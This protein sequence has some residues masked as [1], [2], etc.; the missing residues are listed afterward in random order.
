MKIKTYSFQEAIEIL[1]SQNK[2]NFDPTVELS[3]NLN[4]DPKYPDQKIKGFI[5]F[6]KILGKKVKCAVV[7]DT[8]EDLAKE[9]QSDFIFKSSDFV[10]FIKLKKRIKF[11]V[12]V[13][14]L[15]TKTNLLKIA[16]EL[17]KKKL[18]PDQKS[19]TLTDDVKNVVDEIKNKRINYA[20]NENGI[21]HL[22]IGKLSFPIEHLKLNYEFA[23]DFIKKNKPKSVKKQFI[24]KITINS[25]MGSSLNLS[26]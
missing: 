25:T 20:V 1:K 15:E 26:F 12:L 4:I 6:P 3:L 8:K 7:T 16:K 11:D 21:L 14:T 17:G 9:A 24:A 10:N 18:F 5:V 23:L 22:I 19:N 2:V 13:A